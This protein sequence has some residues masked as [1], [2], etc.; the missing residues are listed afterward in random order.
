MEIQAKDPASGRIAPGKVLVTGGAGFIGSHLCERLL[1][2]GCEVVCLD[3]FNDFYDPAIKRHNIAGLLANP[4]FSLHEGDIRDVTLVN[5]LFEGERPEAVAHLAAMAGVRP[6]IEE[7]VLYYDVNVTGTAVVLEAARKQ[8]A[9]NFIFGSSSSVYGSQEKTPFSEKDP[10]S[11]PISPYAASKAAGELLCHTCHHLFGMPITCLRFF[12]VY[13]PRQRPEM[14]IHLFAKLIRDGKAVTV[15]GDGHSRR[16]YTFVED[17]I[18]GI[19]RSLERPHG[20][21]IF[22]LGESRTVELLELIGLIEKGV[23]R[24]AILRM[25]PVQPGDVPVTFADID[26]ARS[27]LGYNPSTPIEE[28][29]ERFIEW[30]S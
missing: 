19:V 12:T 8:G 11:R 26:H 22:N 2:L 9:S 23:G 14:A 16:D 27:S 1:E 5:T 20:Y 13:G 18:D 7:P 25:L 28:G 10:V 30:F 17:I 6:S 21:E 15:Y 4:G 3:N 24:K 29:I